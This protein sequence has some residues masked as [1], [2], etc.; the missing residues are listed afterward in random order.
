MAFNYWQNLEEQGIYH[1]YNR[2]VNKEC[3]FKDSKDYAFF[4]MKIQQYLLPYL[5]F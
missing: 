1:L 3:L 5:E 2:S 4:L